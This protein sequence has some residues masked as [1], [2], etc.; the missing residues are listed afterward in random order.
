MR[1]L[2][3]QKL[4]M[5]CWKSDQFWLGRLREFPDLMSQARTPTELE[6]NL[7]DA[8]PMVALD[9]VRG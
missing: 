2:I 9:D 7:R 5:I 6:E 1:A 4:T 3:Q 8:C